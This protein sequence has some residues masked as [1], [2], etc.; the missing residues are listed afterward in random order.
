MR[1]KMPKNWNEWMT[2]D[3]VEAAGKLIQSELENDTETTKGYA[4]YA[5]NEALRGI[6]DSFTT[7]KAILACSAE[8]AGN[9]RVFDAYFDGSGHLDVWIEATA[10]TTFGFIEVGAYLTDI[11][12]T[13][14][15]PY[16]EHMCIQ[17]YKRR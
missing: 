11:W 10:K 8:I 1:V 14:A 15:T 4:C 16:K 6:K 17:Y 7:Q 13:G 3:D 2:A 9:A 12:Q 5:I